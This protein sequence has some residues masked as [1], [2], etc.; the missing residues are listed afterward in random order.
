MYRSL[1]QRLEP[2]RKM[3]LA[4]PKEN[5]ESIMSTDLGRA[6]IDD[7]HLALLIFDPELEVIDRWIP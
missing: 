2:G 4:L 1:L 6:M 3:V 7:Y 5:W